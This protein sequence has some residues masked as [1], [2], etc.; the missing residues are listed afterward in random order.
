MTPAEDFDVAVIG[1]SIAGCTAARLFAQRG[2]R[3]ALIERHPD[4]DA[5][6]TACTHFVQSS[7]TPTIERLGLAPLLERRGAVHNSIDFWAPHGGWIVARPEGFGYSLTRRELDPMLRRLA[8]E[9]PGVELLAGWTAIGLLGEGRPRGV[10]IESTAHEVRE[11]RARLLVAAD[12]RGSKMARFAGVRA[13]SK[14][15][16]RF[17]YWAYWSGLRPAGTRARIWV[18]EPDCAYTFPNE[19]GLTLALVAPHQ[20]RLS[21]FRADREGAYM[22][23]LRSLP[24]APEF[25]GATR[26]SKLLGKLDAPN[27]IRPAA[28]PGLA[29]VGDAALAADPFWGIGCGWAFQSSEWLVEETAPALRGK[30]DLDA[31]LERYRRLHRWR[32]GPHCIQTS[33]FSTRGRM[34][35]L[36]RRAFHRA[37]LDPVFARSLVKVFARER[38]V[39]HLLR[40]RVGGR[41]LIGGAGQSGAV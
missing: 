7:A 17:F 38:S 36:E 31:A 35:S 29:F 28:R 30:G 2:L 33:D 12:G 37:T 27:S 4:L 11:V 16:C 40:P 18:L 39:F 15:N 19:D 10:R 1:A 21:E 9:T 13:R 5:Y 20:D 24:D 23:M 14:P 3:V 34:T 22:R 8:A 41:L 32:L 25:D 6:K 26:E